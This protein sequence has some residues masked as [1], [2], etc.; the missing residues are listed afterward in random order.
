MGQSN[1]VG[2]DLITLEDR[3]SDE[4]V[5]VLGYETCPGTQRVV[6]QWDTALPP[7]HTCSGGIDRVITLPKPLLQHYPKDTPWA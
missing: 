3:T 7:L 1:M 2:C 4:R 5:S 6:N